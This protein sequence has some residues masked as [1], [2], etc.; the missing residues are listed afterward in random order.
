ML[1]K[2]RALL[3]LIL[4]LFALP[5]PALAAPAV[6]NTD[7]DGPGSL[8]KAIADAADGDTIDVPP[9]TYTLTTG[10]LEIDKPLTLAGTDARSTII[11][12]G[13]NSRAIIVDSGNEVHI[14]HLMVTNGN[15]DQG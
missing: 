4:A 2:R 8:R 6:T 3:T 7:D 12:A 15:A 13:G 9:G 5:A 14:S 11:D 10:Q 1:A